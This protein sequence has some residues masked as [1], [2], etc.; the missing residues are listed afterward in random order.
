MGFGGPKV[1]GLA[2]PDPF[3]SRNYLA[4]AQPVGHLAHA[5]V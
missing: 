2:Q 4:Q 5:G 1:G 3:C